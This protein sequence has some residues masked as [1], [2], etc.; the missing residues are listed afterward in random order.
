MQMPRSLAH[1]Q[2]CVE[3]VGLCGC[4]ADWPHSGVEGLCRCQTGTV[5]LKLGARLQLGAPTA[6]KL[7]ACLLCISVWVRA[8][9]VCARSRHPRRCRATWCC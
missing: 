8:E 4:Q 3:T 7:T 5:L 1:W 6:V 9:C 2:P